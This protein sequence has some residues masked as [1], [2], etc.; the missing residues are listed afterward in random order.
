MQKK[1]KLLKL[2]DIGLKN[3][4]KKAII[5]DILTKSSKPTNAIDLHKECSQQIRVDLVTVYRTLAQLRQKG[6]VREILGVDGIVLYEY[7]NDSSLMHPHFQCM[8]CGALFCLPTLGFQD[9]LYFA[10]MAKGFEIQRINVTIEGHCPACI[11]H[12]KEQS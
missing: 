6:V 9:A 10:N 11:N 3:T 5:L 4:P 7:S 1:E 12:Q 8:G 2:S